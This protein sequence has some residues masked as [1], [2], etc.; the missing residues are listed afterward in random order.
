MSSFI[1]VRRQV[2]FVGVIAA[3]LLA[4]VVPILASA[5][6]I[7]TR[8]IALSDASKGAKDVSYTLKFTPATDAVAAVID[9]CTGPAVGD[10]CTA[11]TGLSA[12]GVATSGGFTLYTAGNAEDA[13]TVIVAGT[14]THEAEATISLTGIDNPTVDGTI[15]ARVMTYASTSATDDYASDNIGSAVDT[16]SIS[17]AI[18]DTIS[19]SGS[20]NESLIFCVS[21]ET[22]GADCD[23]AADSTP[24]LELGV[25][26][27]ATKALQAGVLSTADLFAQISTNAA[28]GATVNLK[29]SA[30]GCG[31]LINSSK[32]EECYIAPALTGGITGGEAKF[33][34]LVDDDSAEEPG[35][36]G[37][38]AIASGSNYNASTYT[39]N[40]AALDAS[41][42]TS[43]FG[44]PILNTNDQPISNK[45]KKF[46][47]GASISNTTPAG[48]YST[49]LSL[50]ATG[51]F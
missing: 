30:A 17:A 16:G 46:T 32:P 19:V 29:S 4:L 41:G 39:L 26:S 38:F 43:V 8:S 24:T 5:A 23:V 45:N 21:S 1:V 11:P 48:K 37:T 13:N 15:Y 3:L 34:V 44:D 49:N 6:D 33:G 27:G 36:T 7:T 28:S 42:V 50:I 25:G 18:H 35:G 51:K 31:G 40:Y 12:T 22:I 47:F 20:V 10:T 9:F 2:A 14:L